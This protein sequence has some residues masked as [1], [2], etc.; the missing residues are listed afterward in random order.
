MEPRGTPPLVLSTKDFPFKVSRSH[1]LLRKEE[2]NLKTWPKVPEDLILLRRLASQTLS[3]A[4]DILSAMIWVAP[5]MLKVL[6]I[7]SSILARIQAAP[8]ALEEAITVKTLT[9][10]GVTEVLCSF[11]LVLQGKVG[12]QL[13]DR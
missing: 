11:R 5:D 8:D 2:L 10:S 9:I 13:P 1:L 3:K 12:G 6:S 4:F 7:L